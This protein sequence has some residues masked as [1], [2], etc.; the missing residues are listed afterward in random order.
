VFARGPRGDDR[1]ALFQ[2]TTAGQELTLDAGRP[3]RITVRDRDDV[4]WIDV[5]KEASAP[6]TLRLPPALSP[7]IVDELAVH[8]GEVTRIRRRPL[9]G[10]DTSRVALADLSTVPQGLAARGPDQLFRKLFTAPFGPAALARYD[11]ER[12]QAPA[13]TFGVSHDDAVR[14]THLLAQIDDAQREFRL[15]SAALIAAVGAAGIAGAAL[16]PSYVGDTSDAG[17]VNTERARQLVAAG[18]V[19]LVGLGIYQALRAP[20]NEHLHAVLERGLANH[21]DPG[22]LVAGIDRRLHAAATTATRT[23]WIQGGIGALLIAGSAAAYAYDA[24]STEG[25]R[26]FRRPVVTAVAALGTMTLLTSLLESPIE[27]TARLWD[28]DPGI[29]LPSLAIIPARGGATLSLSRGF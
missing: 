3:I 1:T 19:L 11:A 12:V 14:M 29:A 16:T 10:P 8:H 4:A 21:D 9:P 17:G 24:R 5:Y 22:L 2:P 15:L 28:D 25:I 27:R 20:A 18:G 7:A 26:Q 6:L 23:R 13:P